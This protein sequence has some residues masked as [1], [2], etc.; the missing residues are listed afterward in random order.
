MAAHHPRRRNAQATQRTIFVATICEAEYLAWPD[1][2]TFCGPAQADR[3]STPGVTA[4][5]FYHVYSADDKEREILRRRIA[6]LRLGEG[7]TDQSVEPCPYQAADGTWIPKVYVYRRVEGNIRRSEVHPAEP[8]AFES[9]ATA[10]A[11]SLALGQH[12]LE[13]QSS[14]PRPKPR[15]RS[16]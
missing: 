2:A 9:E 4:E 11:W 6:E 15:Q 16:K 3:R 12:S 8:V 10:M 14:R 13:R 5:S 7:R 1:L